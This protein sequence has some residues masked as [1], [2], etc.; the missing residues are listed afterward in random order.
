MTCGSNGMPE[1]IVIKAPARNATG[2][3]IIIM[4]SLGIDFSI[5]YLSRT[6]QDVYG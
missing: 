4:T 6:R 3:K 5:F 1:A 2:I